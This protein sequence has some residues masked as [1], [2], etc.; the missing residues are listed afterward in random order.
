MVFVFLPPKLREVS[1]D[2]HNVKELQASIK[3][4]M[5]QTQDFGDLCSQVDICNIS[6]VMNQEI[7]P[8]HIF[9]KYQSVPW[10]HYNTH[11]STSLIST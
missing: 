3:G 8:Q 9:Q 1:K 7:S 4:F 5:M 2:E 11:L 10:W 6:S